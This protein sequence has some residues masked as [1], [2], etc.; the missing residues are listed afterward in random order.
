MCGETG[1]GA[2]WGAQRTGERRIWARQ[3]CTGGGRGLWGTKSAS[4]GGPL[5]EEAVRGALQ[6]R[7][8]MAERRAGRRGS[9]SPPPMPSPP[10]PQLSLPLPG[11]APSH[12]ELAVEIDA[13]TR[14]L[15]EPSSTSAPAS[16]AGFRERQLFGLNVR[17]PL[18]ASRGVR[19]ASHSTRRGLCAV[20]AGPSRVLVLCGVCVHACVRACVRGCVL[21]VTCNVCRVDGW[22]VCMYVCMYV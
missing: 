9:S 3:T 14:R 19:R 20:A 22:C 4:G 8:P 7:A 12:V 6:L 17:K 11:V 2:G 18:G 5:W 13:S 21:C 1:Q 10:P 15:G 16:A